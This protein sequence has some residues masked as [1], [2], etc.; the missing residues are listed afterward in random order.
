M[1]FISPITKTLNLN[2]N[3]NTGQSS[4]E[5]FMK[6]NL[7]NFF[8]IVSNPKHEYYDFATKR[9]LYQQKISNVTA[10]V[11]F[12]IKFRYDKGYPRTG[13]KKLKIREIYKGVKSW[14]AARWRYI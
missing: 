1:N 7:N 10:Y 6:F 2:K 8:E 5:I 11:Q 13:Y 3:A 4:D 9:K 12:H 14:N